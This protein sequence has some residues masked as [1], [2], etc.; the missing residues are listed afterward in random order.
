MCP[1]EPMEYVRVGWSKGEEERRRGKQSGEERGGKERGGE[2]RKGERR[3][4]DG[5]A[6][7]G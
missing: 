2:E 4:R 7:T 5:M 6:Q 3:R 1:L